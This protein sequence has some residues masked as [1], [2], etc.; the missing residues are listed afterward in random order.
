MV[1]YMKNIVNDPQLTFLSRLS[2][3]CK[4]QNKSVPSTVTQYII[5]PN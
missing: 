5:M 2:L 3:N 4:T 1:S